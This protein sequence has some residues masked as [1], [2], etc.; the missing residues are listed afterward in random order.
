VPPDP[1]GAEGWRKLGAGPGL[2][3]DCQYAKLTETRR[4]PAY[5]RCTRAE[6]D[7]TLPRYPRLPVLKCPGFEPLEGIANQWL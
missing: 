5:L 7:A 1:G 6:W 3:A 4:G 2:C